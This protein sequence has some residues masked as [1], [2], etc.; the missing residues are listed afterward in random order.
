MLFSTVHKGRRRITSTNT[1]GAQCAL[2][3]SIVILPFPASIASFLIA[4]FF[5]SLLRGA[6]FSQGTP[7]LKHGLFQHCRH[8][9][10][11]LFVTR[12]SSLTPPEPVKPPVLSAPQEQQTY[13]LNHSA[14]TT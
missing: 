12:R 14:G 10:F 5:S 7:V 4:S 6:K 1:F 9:L 3:F 13:K 11:V 8:A 2:P